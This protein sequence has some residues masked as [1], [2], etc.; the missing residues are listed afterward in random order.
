VGFNAKYT[1]TI[2][3]MKVPRGYTPYTVKQVAFSGS[4]VKRTKTLKLNNTGRFLFS[5]CARLYTE[6]IYPTTGS[7]L[8][9]IIQEPLEPLDFFSGYEPEDYTL[10]SMIAMDDMDDA[11]MDDILNE[12]RDEVDE[13]D[14]WGQDPISSAKR[15]AYYRGLK[16]N[17]KWLEE[18]RD[19][20]IKTYLEFLDGTGSRCSCLS[21]NVFSYTTQVVHLTSNSFLVG[22]LQESIAIL[23][24]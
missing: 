23:N 18:N 3:K 4:G 5:T 8:P 21:G 1:K 17:Q 12:V 19:V 15:E 22:S 14:S 10:N 7:P 13:E 20:F 24:V 6:S 9:S 11:I 2:I 16:D